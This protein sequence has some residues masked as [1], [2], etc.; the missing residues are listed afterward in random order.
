MQAT[1]AN[2][3][4]M[5]NIVAQKYTGHCTARS[6]QVWLV[7]NFPLNIIIYIPDQIR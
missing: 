3:Y 7:I 2:M 6:F 1:V 5:S 4:P